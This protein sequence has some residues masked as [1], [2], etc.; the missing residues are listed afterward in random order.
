MKRLAAVLAFGLLGCP[1]PSKQGQYEQ[2]VSS[3]QYLHSWDPG[4][5]AE[6][7]FA[8]DA[9]MGSDDHILYPLVGRLTDETPTAI[10]DRIAGR[11]V[12]VGDVAFLLLLK[13]MNKKW[14]DFAED[15]VFM[16]KLLPNPIFGL[17]F[18]PG[19]RAR[20]KARFIPMLPTMEELENK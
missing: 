8:Y 12:V 3:I 16:S 10:H 1:E 9:I 4:K 19:A 14:E 15:G 20:V 7:Q 5:E 2:I 11:T 6:G 17:K 18:D 13:R